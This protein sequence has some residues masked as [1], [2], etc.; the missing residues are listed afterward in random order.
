MDGIETIDNDLIQ[1][2]MNDYDDDL[3]RESCDC[4]F[5]SSVRKKV[6]NENEK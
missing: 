1:Q 4:L 3:I 6:K 5:P 2:I